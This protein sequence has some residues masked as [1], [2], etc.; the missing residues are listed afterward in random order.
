VFTV[1]D[2]Q[3]NAWLAQ[4]LW[5]FFRMLAFLSVDPFLSTRGIPIRTR[6][7]LALM[8]SI[9]L[10]NTIP[11]MPEVATVSA[12]GVLII[13]EQIVIGAALG[14]VMRIVFTAVEMAGNIA[15]LQMGLGFASFFDPQHGANTAVVAQLASLMTLLLFL[16][17]DGHLVVLHTMARSFDLIPISATPMHTGALQTLVFW[18]GQIFQLGVLMALPVLAALLITNLSIGVMA[19]AAPQFNVFAIGFPLTM[20]VGFAALYFSLPAF[21]TYVHRLIEVGTQLAVALAKQMQSGAT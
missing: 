3:I 19:R 12:L 7:G 20:S 13:M 16:S 8:I 4:L 14:F 2:A 15:G 9:L 1:S 6:L 10:A 21:S 11:P 17:M 5:P 18:G